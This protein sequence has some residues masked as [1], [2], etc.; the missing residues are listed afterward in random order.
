MKRIAVIAGVVFVALTWLHSQERP[1][2]TNP[3]N[4]R[5]QLVPAVIQVPVTPTALADV[6]AVFLVDS[7][8]GKVWKYQGEELMPNF[9]VSVEVD[10]LHGLKYTDAYRQWNKDRN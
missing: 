7:A 1:E 6:H 4:A 8:T 10:G 9:F 2:S 5:Y 3:N